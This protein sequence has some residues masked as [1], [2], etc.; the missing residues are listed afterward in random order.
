MVS[1]QRAMALIAHAF[2]IT[3]AINTA[4]AFTRAGY[5]MDMT[6]AEKILASRS[7]K[8][9]VTASAIEGKIADPR[10]YPEG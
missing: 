1:I 3:L 9:V 5:L 4:T 2:Q 6:M 8:A 10:K 7:G